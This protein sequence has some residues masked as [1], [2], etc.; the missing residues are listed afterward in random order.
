MPIEN[1]N[2]AL[3]DDCMDRFSEVVKAAKK[4][5][6]K[7]EQE[8]ELLGMMSGSIDSSK[9]EKLSRV[10]GVAT[11][12]RAQEYQLPPPDSEVQ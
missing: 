8:L 5:G 11:V 2:V 3:A 9:L 12:E 1:V 4:A 10:P 6:L 7:V